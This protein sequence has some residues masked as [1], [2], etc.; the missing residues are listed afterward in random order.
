[1]DENNKT[2]FKTKLKDICL[3]SYRAYNRSNHLYENITK[4][5]YAALLELKSY[6]DLIIQ[7]GDK[8]NN[9]VILDKVK[10]VEKI[11]NILNDEKKFLHLGLTDKQALDALISLEQRIKDILTPLKDKNII[12]ESVFNKITPVGSQPGKLY[13]LCKVHKESVDGCPP[14]RPIISA[15]NTLTYHLAKFLLPILEPITKNS[16]VIKDLKTKNEHHVMASFDV[17]SLFTNI[18]LDE[19]IDICLSKLYPRRNMKIKGMTKSEFKNLLEIATKESLF[20]FNNQYFKQLDG[21]AMGSPLGPT[22]ANIFLCY[23]E[24]IWLNKC[25]TQ[26]KPVYYKRYVDDTF[27]LF[28]EEDHIKKFD[29]YL[30]SR[31]IN[32]RFT[33]EIESDKSLNF[34]DV[35]IHKNNG[36]VTSIYR[37]PT[38]SGIYSHYDS[39]LPLVYKRGLISSLMFRIFHLSSNW[40]IIHAEIQNLKAFLIKN[41]YPQKFVES[42]ICSILEKLILKPKPSNITEEK[43]EYVICLPY[44]G[45]QTLTLKKRLSKLFSST[46]PKSK[47]KIIFKSGLKLSN[48][49]TY[50][51]KTPFI[52]QSLVLYKFSCSSCNATYIGKTK[53]HLMTRT[54][55]HLGISKRTGKSLK[56]NASQATVVQQHLVTSTHLGNIDNFKVIGYAR[57]D[58]ELL[59]KESLIISKLDPSLNKQVESF[60]LQLF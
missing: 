2:F 5:E 20:M 23:H 37:K 9:V 42:S 11:K 31:H 18:P 46:Y 50:K 21:V 55:E 53:R 51:D 13:G 52:I 33:Y 43:K 4:E 29:K 1:M 19:T 41:K 54:C 30:N 40:S 35:L 6:D 56:Y 26:F 17:E 24:E 10:Y 38:F 22:L 32:M 25:P 7:K 36:F 58:F 49:F 3:S 28:K 12:D 44:L 48:I 47:L 59:I 57:N 27:L 15:I 16:F 14:F 39:F 8:G 34:L 45:Q 60:R